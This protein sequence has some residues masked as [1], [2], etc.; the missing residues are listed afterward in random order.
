MSVPT[1]HLKFQRLWL[2]VTA[3]TLCCGIG[4]PW[5]CLARGNILGTACLIAILV[6]GQSSAEDTRKDPR[7]PTSAQLEERFKRAV[8]SFKIDF[9]SKAITGF[10]ESVLDLPKMER[11]AG[12][13]LKLT[14]IPYPNGGLFIKPGE[15]MRIYK[16]ENQILTTNAPTICVFVVDDPKRAKELALFLELFT[17]HDS[18]PDAEH[19]ERSVEFNNP[20]IGDLCVKPKTWLRDPHGFDVSTSGK[21]SCAFAVGNI[22]VAIDSGL[23][24][25]PKIDVLK[26]AKDLADMF[27]LSGPEQN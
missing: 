7:M 9:R 10:D 21:T 1:R 14:V 5:A 26:I 6:H 25:N 27:V 11:I 22:A 19:V 4:C 20:K 15:V 24:L 8:D 3:L 17:L 18:H 23:R 13:K 12:A 2:N 16:M